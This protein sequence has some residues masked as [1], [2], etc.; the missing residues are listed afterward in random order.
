MKLIDT[1]PDNVTIRFDRGEIAVLRITM[2]MA[3]I[4]TEKTPLM[5]KTI[6]P[7]AFGEQ[8]FLAA[9]KKLLDQLEVITE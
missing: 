5:A 7:D 6:A 2:L 8:D 1:N 3:R 9:Q 4:A